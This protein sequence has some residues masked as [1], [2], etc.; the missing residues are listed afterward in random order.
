MSVK[1]TSICV[2]LSVV[3]SVL[4]KNEKL[5]S[6]DGNSILADVEVDVPSESVGMGVDVGG[7]NKV[8]VCVG[9]A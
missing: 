7:V 8:A 3:V 2:E 5:R 6:K 9:E 4:Y 1:E